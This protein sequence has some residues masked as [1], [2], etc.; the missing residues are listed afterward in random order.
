MIIIPNEGKLA[1][2]NT[3]LGD[4]YYLKLFTNDVLHNEDTLSTWTLAQ[5]IEASGGGYTSKT[6]DQNE[7]TTVEQGSNIFA[8]NTTYTWNF[9][10]TLSGVGTC[11]YGYY[12]TNQ[13]ED[14]LIAICKFT[15]RFYV[16]GSGA[17]YSVIP[18]INLSSWIT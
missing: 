1:L 7:W 9:T 14:S 12:I 13:A 3:I 4:F 17:F 11:I 6:I 10:G 16:Y 5:T 8:Y 2:S 18:S 15:R